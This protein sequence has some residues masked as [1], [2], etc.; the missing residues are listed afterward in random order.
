MV[1]DLLAGFLP[2]ISSLGRKAL[3]LEGTCQRRRLLSQHAYRGRT[4][5]T[6]PREVSEAITTDIGNALVLSIAE[7]PLQ[8]IVDGINVDTRWIDPFYKGRKRKPYGYWND[9]RAVEKEIM[10]L[11][12]SLGKKKPKA[13]PLLREMTAAGRGDLVA[14]IARYGG[15]KRLLGLLGWK[16][17]LMKRKEFGLARERIEKAGRKDIAALVTKY[18]GEERFVRRLFTRYSDNG[19][20]LLK[21]TKNGSGIPLPSILEVIL[22]WGRDISFGSNRAKKDLD[23]VVTKYGGPKKLYTILACEEKTGRKQGVFS[24]RRRGRRGE[25][26]RRNLSELKSE[27]SKYIYVDS[28][29]EKAMPTI[30]ELS[31][32]GRQ[33]LVYDIIAV[34]GFKFVAQQFNLPSKGKWT[35]AKLKE[36]ILKFR[37]TYHPIQEAYNEM[38]TEPQLRK[39]GRSDMSYAIQRFGGHSKVR[40][41]LGLQRCRSWKLENVVV[42]IPHVHL[43]RA[44]RE[45]FKWDELTK[46]KETDRKNS[47]RRL[48]KV[49]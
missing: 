21:R 18:G 19:K 27:L 23:S 6:M 30:S 4:T 47:L 29:N 20:E 44:Q 48:E 24:K 46:K 39:E 45:E 14:M 42:T 16:G 40:D 38:P 33:D 25:V 5:A 49:G 32:Q 1:R 41:I 12:K 36:E 31:K 34:G 2:S 43:A 35:L 10:A 17:H 13:I 22:R 9:L 3:V 8:N 15:K 7:S 37:A 28:S 11:N 26:R